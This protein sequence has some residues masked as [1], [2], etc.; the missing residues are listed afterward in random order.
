[1][2]AA[3]GLHRL[4]GLPLH[5]LIQIPAILADAGIAYLVALGLKRTGASDR[6]RLG[7]AALVMLGPTFAY[8]SGY[9][10]QFDSVAVLPA[11]TALIV[12]TGP[13]PEGRAL[14]AGALVGLA[15]AFKHPL[16]I[17][18][19]PLLV[20]SRSR[21]EVVRLVGAAVAVP[22][23]AALPFL[24]ATPHDFV[25]VLGYKGLRGLGGISL[26][27]DP[28][29]A[30]G[31]VNHSPVETGA[32]EMKLLRHAVELNL[33]WVTLAGALL[34]WR[35]PP[36]REGFALLWLAFLAIA[37]A[38]AF[39]YLVWALPFFLLA[40]W[41]REVVAIQ[42]L[43]LAPTIIFYGAPWHVSAL[44]PVYVVAMLALWLA[45]CARFGLAVVRIVAPR[46]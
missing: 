16:L 20:S 41:W 13:R 6:V 46:A 24:V 15:A 32:L 2:L 3:D 30:R 4:T 36:P 29:L 42:A 28:E 38:F 33:V 25:H 34:A 17:C 14:R 12:W 23:A 8:V 9:H 18:V 31:W 37:P 10:G 26:V 7:S 21:G 40:G 45:L 35:R 5:G 27:L 19:L 1:M 43:A 39:W 11:V 44:V 22:V